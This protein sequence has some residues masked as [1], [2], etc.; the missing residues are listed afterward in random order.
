MKLTILGSGSPEPTPRRASS[1]YLVEIGA[2]RILFDCGGG[3]V[4]NLI[5]SGRLPQD[6]THLVF[7]HLHSDHMMDYA[8]LVHAAWDAGALPLKVFGPAPIAEVTR[9]LFGPEGAFAFD[10]HARTDLKPSQEV[11]LARGGTLPR[12]WPRPEIV[13]IAAG[14]CI[15]GEGWR[16]ESCTVPHAQPI[17]D[18]FG[19]ALRSGGRNGGRNGEHS[20]GRSFVYSGDA[21]LCAPLRALAQDADLLLHWCYR[22]DGEAAPAGMA[23]VTPTPSEIAAMAAEIGVKRLMLTHFR[24][25]MDSDANIAAALA[26]MRADFDGPVSVA[27]DLESHTI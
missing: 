4:G 23:S 15:E 19:F 17:L 27:E 5:R 7:S 21:G 22:L 12:P 25:H 9:R 20:G 16:I 24:A 6:I 14:D 10:L 13:E 8:R 18:C 3:V 2:D 26:A 11:W 1:G